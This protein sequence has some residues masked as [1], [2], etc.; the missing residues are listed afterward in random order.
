MRFA[1]P[2]FV[3]LAVLLLLPASALAQSSLVGAVTDNTGGV[4]PGVTVEA[5][6]P[7]LIEGSRVAITDGTGRYAIVDLR[8]GTYTVTMT[9]PGFSTFVQEGIEVPASTNVTIDG[10]L[11]VGA[12]EETVT[13]SAESPVVD[14]Q[15]AARTEVM[16]R[17]T[18]DALPTPR[19]TQSI[20][21]LA[22]GVRLTRPDVGGAQMMEQV[23]MSVHGATPRHTT[24]QVD[25][26]IVNSQMSDGLI[27]NYNNQALSQEMAMTTSGNPAE[28]AAG[29]LRLN[30][31]PK[32]GGNQI[33]GSNYVG[34]T[35]NEDWQADNFTQEIQDLGLTSNQGVTNIHDI[36]P[37]LGGPILR[38]RLWYFASA[39]AISVDELF[40]GAF[41]PVLRTDVAPEVIQDYFK[42]GGRITCEDPNK[43]IGCVSTHPAVASAT[44]AVAE[45]H[46]RSALLRLTAQ[47]SQ[48]NKVSAYLDRIFKWKKREFSATRE[49]IQ[50][51]GFRDPGQANY[52]TFQA[53]WTST[54]SSRALLEVGYSQVYERLLISNQPVE[55]LR[56]VYPENI[57]VPDL[58]PPV[59]SN[60]RTCIVTPCYWDA[61]YDQTGPW[62][63]NAVIGDDGHG[64]SRPTTTGATSGSRR[65]TGATRTRPSRTSPG[66]TTSRS[67]CSGRSATTATR[68]TRPG[69]INI[70]VRATGCRSRAIPDPT[71][72]CEDRHGIDANN[73]PVSWNTT[74]RAD[75]GIYVQ[76]TWTLDR[77]TINA[78]LRWDHFE[79]V[80]NTFR[81]GDLPAGRFINA[82]G[83]PEIPALPYWNDIAPRFS[84]V[85]DLFGDA[86]T[87]LKFSMNKFMRPYASGH[88][89]RYSPYR[90]RGERRQWFDCVLKPSIHTD[91]ETGDPRQD[92]ATAADLGGLPA[93]PEYYLSQNYDGIAQDHEIGL[94]SNATVFA[95]GNVAQSGARPADDLQREYNWETHMGI[96]HEL[97][98]RVSLNVGYFRRVFSD[99]EQ[100]SDLSLLAC[101]INTA[102]PGVPCGSWIPFLVSFNDPAGRWAELQSLGQT[103]DIDTTPFLAYDLDPAYQGRM[104]D[105]LDVTSDINRNY[106]NG[107][108]VSTNVRLPNGGTIFG[109]WTAHQHIQDT[110]GLTTN[111]NGQGIEDPIRGS[112]EGVLRGGRFCNQSELGIPFRHDF[113]LFAAYPLPYDF[114]FSGSIQAYSGGER[115]LRWSIPTSYFPGGT[116]TQGATVQV[117]A[118]G[119]NYYD[120][121]TQVDIALRR[122]FR[123]GNYETS[124]QADIY[125]LMNSAVVVDETDSYG[126]SWGR[127]TRLLQGRLL[128][129]AFQVKW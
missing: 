107:F 124:V 5:T 21:Y 90:E 54:I 15:S 63:A 72:P 114:E 25:G 52:H 86:R 45:Q 76:D 128:R 23:R 10:S 39:R 51:A 59:P 33:A 62:F 98:P 123:F 40:A 49:P 16:Q 91:G 20:G 103:I 38:D 100:R 7:V 53:K 29:G 43:S 34:F 121:W 70:R 9:L 14:V 36:N 115:E 105:Q 126:G 118:P 18:I 109:G 64:A 99:I 101:D 102:Q 26:M 125:N 69:H 65:P 80:I 74:V 113:K 79:S 32:D 60:L 22:Q 122:I 75:R 56:E 93:S 67:A 37:A 61:G 4:L 96:Q 11:S 31:I 111:P 44:R 46:V 97:F 6:S 41:A 19:N 3:V 17:D 24:M 30:M 82:R 83:A 50:A 13:V 106:Y 110:C 77:L 89:E 71:V 117:F 87:A 27:M 1:K 73:Y 68:G 48:R 66:R 78:G 104:V 84:V 35:L 81:T 116:R 57:P 120:Y 8:P 58:R 94:L 127:P 92:C 47:V 85:Y 55:A 42:R 95:E 108:E 119:T 129:L 28:V 112:D 2:L 88:A 12:L